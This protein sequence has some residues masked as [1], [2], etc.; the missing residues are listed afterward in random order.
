MA[1]LKEIFDC[2]VCR[3]KAAGVIATALVAILISYSY[4][5]AYRW[6]IWRTEFQAV[7][8]RVYEATIPEQRRVVSSVHRLLERAKAIPPVQRDLNDDVR[9]NQLESDLKAE[10]ENLR[11]LVEERAKFTK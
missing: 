8:G 2:F 3:I 9:I 6:W 10:E 11:E 7:A 5:D 4:L 1:K